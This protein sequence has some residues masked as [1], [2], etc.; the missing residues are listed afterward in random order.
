MCTLHNPC[1]DI[2]QWSLL[3]YTRDMRS[4]QWSKQHKVLG[5]K[6]RYLYFDVV[7]SFINLSA[8]SRQPASHRLQLKNYK[9]HTVD[10][11]LVA[12]FPL[13]L[14]LVQ[15]SVSQTRVGWWCVLLS[16]VPSLLVSSQ[17]QLRFGSL[18]VKTTP[19]SC[20]LPSLAGD[21]D[22]CWSYTFKGNKVFDRWSWW[23]DSGTSNVRILESNLFVRK[24]LC[25]FR[26]KIALNAVICMI[27]YIV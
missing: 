15:F 11:Q 12:L 16:S 24:Y 14:V 26:A 5:A 23:G 8:I 18:N 9:L 20:H 7:F 6:W 3:S 2:T 10:L 21:K 1:L 17:H 25:N 4:R 19:E 22:C 13:R 27:C